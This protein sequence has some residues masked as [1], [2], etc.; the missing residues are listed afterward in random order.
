[1]DLLIGNPEGGYKTFKTDNLGSSSLNT[2][3][4]ITVGFSGGQARIHFGQ[5]LGEPTA[6]RGVFEFGDTEIRLLPTE[7][8]LNIGHGNIDGE[9]VFPFTG[10]LDEIRFTSGV[11]ESTTVPTRPF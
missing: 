8:S 5:K 3:N 6:A 10:E 7:A 1:L 9:K 2:W 11:R 4:Y